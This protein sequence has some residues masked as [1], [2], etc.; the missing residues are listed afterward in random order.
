M[1]DSSA[2]VLIIRLDGIGDALALTPLLAAFR[3]QRIA[4]DIVLRPGNARIFSS[5]AARRVVTATFAMR[6]NE[7]ADRAAIAELGGDLAFHGYTH[8]LVATED[9]AGYRLARA[10]GAPVR[11]GFTNGIGK[12]LKSLWVRSLLTHAIHRSAGLDRRAPHECEVLFA[13]GASLLPGERPSRNIETLRPLVIER[14][15]PPD[16]RIAVQ[17]TDKYERIGIDRATVIAMLQVLA[18]AWPVRAIA[19]AS[20]STYAS[21]VC[22][23]AGV[24]L[25][26]YAGVDEWKST[27][28]CAR[29]LVAPD[30][31]A[32]HV[33]GMTGTPVVAI[34]ANSR[35][36]AL[37]TARWAPWAAP[38]RIVVV[39]DDAAAAVEAATRA[40]LT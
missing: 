4:V 37:Q 16:E 26:L 6:S 3:R 34:F 15:G 23:A 7:R 24:D 25:E 5:R 12:P 32:T 13:L 14:D 22:N 8:A 27:I 38:H 9:P 17:V 35:G 40:L 19:A 18:G 1:T 31:G 10:S 39:H 20:E 21:D 11:I 29:A 30:S 33:A 28:A 2:S 36:V